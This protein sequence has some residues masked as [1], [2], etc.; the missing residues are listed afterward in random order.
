MDIVKAPPLNPAA[1]HGAQAEFRRETWAIEI[2]PGVSLHS[3]IQPEYWVHCIRN[4]K[5][6]ARIECHA[7]DNK[8]WAELMVRKVDMLTKTAS[9]WVMRYIDLEATEAP[10]ATEPVVEVSEVESKEDE[11][12]GYSISLGGPQRW[13]VVR[14]SD[15]EVIHKGEATKSDAEKWLA[16]YLKQQA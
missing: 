12:P 14:L 10:A 16:D 3:V 7:Q 2:P 1:F 8:W 6:R 9:M 4:L 15:M 5:P 11:M 13:R